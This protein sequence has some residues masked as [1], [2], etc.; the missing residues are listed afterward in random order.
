[1]STL[2]LTL[3]IISGVIWWALAAYG[4][5]IEENAGVG[6]LRLGFMVTGIGCALWFGAT[7]L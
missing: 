6:C 7:C 5:Q 3:A 1:M 2:A 4:P